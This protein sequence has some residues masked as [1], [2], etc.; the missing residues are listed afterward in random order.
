MDSFTGKL[1]GEGPGVA[2]TGS[3]NGAAVAEYTSAAHAAA[4]PAR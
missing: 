3:F 4:E 2:A 1:A